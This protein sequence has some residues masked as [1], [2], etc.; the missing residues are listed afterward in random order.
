MHRRRHDIHDMLRPRFCPR[1]PGILRQD[2]AIFRDDGRFNECP[3][4]INAD[5]NFAH[6]GAPK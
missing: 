2:F 6:D 1:G 4:K 3:T 5:D